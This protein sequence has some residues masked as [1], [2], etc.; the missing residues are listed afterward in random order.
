MQIMMI[1]YLMCGNILSSSSVTFRPQIAN[2]NANG[3]NRDR[4]FSLRIE[5]RREHNWRGEVYLLRFVSFNCTPQR[6][7]S[8]T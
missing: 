7:G 3:Q 2:T 8:S 4:L 6:S 1:S 5:L